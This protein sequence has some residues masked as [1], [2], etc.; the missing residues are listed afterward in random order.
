MHAALIV[1]LMVGGRTIGTYIV[2]T[3]RSVNIHRLMWQC[4]NK[5]ATSLPLRLKTRGSNTQASQRVEIERLINQMGVSLHGNSDMQSI[6]LSTL[7]QIAE[8]LG[9]RRARVRLQMTAL[10]PTDMSKAIGKLLGKLSEK[11]EG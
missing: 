3:A 2:T 9:A 7:Q 11:S 5:L 6:L 8:A 4:S 10:Q 1:P